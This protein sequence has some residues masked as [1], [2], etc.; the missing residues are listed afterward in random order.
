MGPNTDIFP[1]F[2][3]GYFVFYSWA[4]TFATLLKKQ[5]PG[6]GFFNGISD[7]DPIA[8]LVEHLPFKERVLGFE[9]QSD[10]VLKAPF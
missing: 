1:V 4:I 7:H 6:K 2:L 9:P 8:Q 10:H 5:R 3:M